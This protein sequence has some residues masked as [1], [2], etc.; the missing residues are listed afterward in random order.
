M[1]FRPFLSRFPGT[2]EK[3]AAYLRERGAA[4]VVA[5]GS[6]DQEFVG[7]GSAAF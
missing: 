4:L 7:Y 2:K 6:S 5:V 1:A 3:N